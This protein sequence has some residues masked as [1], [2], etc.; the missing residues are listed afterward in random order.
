MLKFVSCELSYYS[1]M[2]LVLVLLKNGMRKV[3]ELQFK[4]MMLWRKQQGFIT[5][6]R[7]NLLI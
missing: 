6:L 3:S 5:M 1:Y 7:F 4:V 2:V